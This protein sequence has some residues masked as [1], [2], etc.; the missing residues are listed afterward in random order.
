[1]TETKALQKPKLRGYFHLEGFFT[2]LGAFVV[3]IA[4]S[5]DLK[6]L[7]AS[8]SFALGILVLFG[9]SAY[10]HVPFWEPKKRA[11]L[12]RLDHAAIFFSIWGG[13]VPFCLLALPENR[14]YPLL[15]LASTIGVVGI[16]HSLVWVNAPKWLTTLF[17][18]GMAWAVFP[19]LDEIG[20]SI[21]QQNVKLLI[22]GGVVYTMGGLFYALKKPKLW[23]M[24]CGYHELCHVC[25]LIGSGCFYYVI[26]QMI[27]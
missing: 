3:M 11:F 6:N 16:L 8:I 14:G 18:I 20:H 22:I 10:Y 27:H 19:Y 26:Y 5:S 17:S 21:G 23:P 4:R 1:M 15:A 24:H 9:I 25:T 7:I 13:F 2:F 12:R